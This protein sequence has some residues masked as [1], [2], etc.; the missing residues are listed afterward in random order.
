MALP[1][2]LVAPLAPAIAPLLPLL[3][4]L[5]ARVDLRYHRSVLV[6]GLPIGVLGVDDRWL[7]QVVAIQRGELLLLGA[8]RRR[9]VIDLD[10]LFLFGLVF[11]L[12]FGLL[13]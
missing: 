12:L 1:I 2:A 9:L 7:G 6:G 5:V 3:L 13:F 10:D 11:G 4:A 8:Q